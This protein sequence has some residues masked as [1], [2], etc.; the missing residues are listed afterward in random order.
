MI[1]EPPRF[2]SRSGWH[3]AAHLISLQL[4]SRPHDIPWKK[5]NIIQ[6]SVLD[7]K[8]FIPDPDSNFPSFGSGSASCYFTLSWIRI[9]D[10]NSESGSMQKFRIH[11]DPDPNPDPTHWLKILAR[12]TLVMF[13][14][15]ASLL[16]Y[17]CFIMQT[18]VEKKRNK[19]IK[20]KT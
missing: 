10:Y 1:P 20:I 2:S 15:T 14:W 11:A 18:F 19:E 4:S 17:F 12:L 16:N 13:I 5:K 7:T 3:C 8:L 9:Q 6:N